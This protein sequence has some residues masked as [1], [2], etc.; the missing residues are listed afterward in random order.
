MKKCNNCD[1]DLELTLRTI[2]SRTLIIKNVPVYSCDSCNTNELVAQDKLQLK[3]II[4]NEVAGKDNVILFEEYSEFAQLILIAL[5][6][7]NYPVSDNNTTNE[8]IKLIENYGTD[9]SEKETSWDKE[10]HKR[11]DK[12]IH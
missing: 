11:I 5:N 6:G 12:L 1:I 8:I 7:Q 3:K 9:Q 10:V 4:I 2:Y